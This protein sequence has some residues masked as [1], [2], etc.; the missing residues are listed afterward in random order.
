MR[1]SPLPKKNK[2]K[3][4][5]KQKESRLPVSQWKIISG[6]WKFSPWKQPS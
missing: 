1:A 3:K 6:Q 2:E 5:T 4:E